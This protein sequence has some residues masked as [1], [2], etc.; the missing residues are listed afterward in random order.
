MKNLYKCFLLGL[1]TLFCLH[2]Q[3]QSNKCATMQ[4]LE[5]RMKKDH[6]IQ[7]RMQQSEIKT[8]KWISANRNAKKAQKLVSIPVVVH[9][10]YNN[11]TQNIS[12][13]QIQSQID[14]LNDDFGLLNSDSLDYSHPF[15]HY[16]ADTEIEFCLATRDPNGKAT[17]GITRTYTDSLSFAGDGYEKYTSTGGKDNW[18]PTKYLNLWVC[19]LSA[20]NGT[21]G[22]A[23]FPSDLDSNPDEDGVV[24]NYTAFGNIGTAT[25]P[26]DLGRTATHEVGH[27]LNLRH[28]WGDSTCGDD[29][30][31]DTEPAEKDNY[32]CPIFPHNANSNCGSGADGEMYMNY[33]DY[34]DD[35][36]MVMFTT[37]QGMRMHAAL[38]VERA[39][40]LTSLGC[41]ISSTINEVL[42][43]NTFDIYPNPNNG[44]FIINAQLT[45]NEVVSITL[46]N[47]LGSKIQQYDNVSTYPFLMS[48]NDLPNGSYFI[49]FNN[50]N[51]T[52]TKKVFISK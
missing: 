18:D 47:L 13:A 20:S 17:S 37:G 51:Y 19:D 31:A 26:N 11:A 14:I 6:S 34:V 23:S 38:N 28:I 33:M 50:G 42:L 32:G 45:K 10:I 9:V 48:L 8:Q 3:A 22:Y 21:L 16:T 39:G 40:L 1:A 24:I 52:I 41:S 25:A 29:F 5:Q 43:E 4:V 7:L 15:W 35:T 12:T 30:V 49:K 44:N 27:W 36:C 2:T 46:Y